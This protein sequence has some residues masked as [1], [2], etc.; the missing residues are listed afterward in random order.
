MRIAITGA[1]GFVGRHLAARLRKAGHEIVTV[2]LAG[3]LSRPDP[4]AARDLLAPASTADVVVNLATALRP[5]TPTELFVNAE[6]PAVLAQTLSDA[7]SDRRLIHVS[8][9][10]VALA[11][12]NDPYTRTKRRAE[13]A[14]AGFTVGIVRPGLI[15]SWR[16]EGPARILDRY[17][18]AP[19]PIHPFPYPGNRYRP[20]L[21]EDFAAFLAQKIEQKDL[22]AVTVLG[23]TPCALW[24]MARAYASLHQRRMVPLAI[25]ALAKLPFLKAAFSKSHTL[26]QF[27]DIDR[28]AVPADGRCVLLPFS[29]QK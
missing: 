5:A 20:V 1:S 8:T 26:I 15:W 22:T 28:S 24:E 3:R 14:L 11:E 6:L 4:D 21:V 12:L 19:L 27:L 10:N 25:G 7:G 23:D 9:A 29:W 2:P 13:A 18:R 16:G 17:F